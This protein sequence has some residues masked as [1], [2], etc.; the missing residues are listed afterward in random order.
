VIEV[1][2][3]GGR[4]LAQRVEFMTAQEHEVTIEII[5]TNLPDAAW[6]GGGTLHLAIQS[7]DEVLDPTPVNRKRFVFRPVLR[8]RRHSDS[9]ANFLGPF[10][11]GA[12]ARAR[13][14]SASSI[15]TGSF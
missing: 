14:A 3:S 12:R 7:G 15:S 5:C 1:E 6:A 8:V 2:F 13:A 10:A 11:H 9:S 4:R